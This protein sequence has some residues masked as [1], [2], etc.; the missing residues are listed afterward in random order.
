MIEHEHIAANFCRLCFF[1]VSSTF[2]LTARRVDGPLLSKKSEMP[3]K[4]AGAGLTTLVSCLIKPELT[5]A[6]GKDS[7]GCTGVKR[8]VPFHHFWPLCE[9]GADW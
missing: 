4:I 7:F 1:K 6:A 3:P 2:F 8:V 9:G 5:V